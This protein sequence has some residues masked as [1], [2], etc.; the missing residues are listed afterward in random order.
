MQLRET[1]ETNRELAQKFAE[2]ERR[3]GKR[4]EEISA[5]IEA[6]RQLMAPPDKP[7]RAIG[8]HVRQKTARYRARNGR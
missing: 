3:V 6:I 5:I 2:L 7:R 1:L 8:F 4:D